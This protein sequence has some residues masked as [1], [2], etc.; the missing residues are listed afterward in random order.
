MNNYRQLV[1]E[2]LMYKISQNG[3]FWIEGKPALPTTDVF[4]K[5]ISV[6]L[7]CLIDATKKGE[8]KY[9]TFFGNLGSEAFSLCGLGGI[10]QA[11]DTVAMSLFKDR[12]NW[13][14]IA[15]FFS[16]GGALCVEAINQGMLTVPGPLSKFLCDALECYC[17][18]W[19]QSHDGW[20]KGFVEWWLNHTPQIWGTPCILL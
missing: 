10:K 19:I 20:D 5:P 4:S 2:F 7:A 14:R 8:N 15:V 12:I 9:S 6:T 3:H 13:G 18:L 1:V 17:G 11:V 16:F